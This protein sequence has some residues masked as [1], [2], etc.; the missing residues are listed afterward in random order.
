MMQ[1][2]LHPRR[3]TAQHKELGRARVALVGVVA[4]SMSATALIG[5]ATASAAAPSFPN[6][7]MVFPDRDFISV[8]GYLD[9][10]GQIATV[11]L[12]RAGVLVGS[13][14]SLVAAAT[15]GD[16]PG[17]NVAFE[18]N[19]PGGVCWGAGTGLNVTPDIQPG[20]VASIS[21]GGNPAGDTRVQDGSVD[22]ASVQAGNTV[23]V[24]GHVG[25]G[26]NTANTEQRLVDHALDAFGGRVRAVPGPLTP[27]A[28]GGY[29]SGMTFNGHTFT[30][31]YVFDDP[32]VA[33]IAGNAPFGRL[34]SWETTDPAGNRQG[35]TISE[36]GEANGPAAGFTPACPAAAPDA[37]TAMT[38]D[39]LN[40]ATVAAGGNVTVSGTSFNSSKVS[41]TVNG[42]T[43]ATAT[44]TPAATLTPLLLPGAQTWTTTIPMSA[45]TAVPEGPLELAMTTNRVTGG[46]TPQGVIPGR[47]WSLTKDTV[48]PPAPSLSLGT[49]SYNGTQLVTATGSADTSVLRYQIGGPGVADPTLSAGA[50]VTGQIAISS[51]QTLKV[52]AFDPV[53]NASPVQAA[54]YTINAPVVTRATP[55]SAPRI[56]TAKSGKPG[57]KVTATATWFAPRSS[58]GSRITSYRIV[59]QRMSVKGKVL[60]T[61]TSGWIKPTARTSVLRL[62]AGTYRLRVVAVNSVGRSPM[63]ARSNKVRAR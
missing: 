30:A 29:S 15:P 27:A 50:T 1:A 4:L 14:K 34:M 17:A 41:L 44:P 39:V 23:T 3:T 5:A 40:Q 62:R 33:A 45:F 18:I 21:F 37:V 35:M 55:P 57:H 13:A 31:T 51:S 59:S 61:T 60:K 47:S 9:H 63:S 53:G 12:T 24:T 8:A 28:K 25:A 19:H 43:F 48:A 46:V 52:V 16:L 38:P 58:G 6:N 10:V 49:G 32:A 42:A 22:A 54:A 11:Q 7:L 20:D 36:F 2:L 56:G 26:V